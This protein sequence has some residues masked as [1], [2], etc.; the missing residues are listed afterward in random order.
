[1][2]DQIFQRLSNINT[3]IALDQFHPRLVSNAQKVKTGLDKFGMAIEHNPT[4]N[5]SMS[6]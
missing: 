5:T 6:P 4:Q 1:M 2:E 3:N